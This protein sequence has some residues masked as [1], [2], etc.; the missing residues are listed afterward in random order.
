MGG[1]K[2]RAARGIGRQNGLGGGPVGGL[3]KK[4]EALTREVR[5]GGCLNGS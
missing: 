2:N 5:G 1:N 3:L 4:N